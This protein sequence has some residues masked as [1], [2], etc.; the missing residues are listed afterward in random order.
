MKRKFTLTI[1]L[2]TMCLCFSGCAKMIVLTEGEEDAIA[3]F[4]A[5]VI[6]KFN[7]NMSKGAT[8]VVLDKP[9]KETPVEEETPQDTPGGEGDGNAG[10]DT[11]DS[12][13]AKP[14]SEVIGIEGLEFSLTG[15]NAMESYQMSDYLDLR[16]N[17]GKVYLAA[18]FKAQNASEAP[19]DVD[20][21]AMKLRFTALV[22]GTSVSSES[23]ILP[24]DLSMYSGQIGPGEEQGLV[25]LFQID[26]EKATEDMSGT[27]L[28]VR[29]DSLVY[30]IAK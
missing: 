16:P 14:L 17:E 18:S 19:I 8:A 25:V 21:K 1:L 20:L 29:K 9:A 30:Q 5:S 22:E 4:S 13:E 27:K 23:T 28:G 10:Q 15:I 7:R 11:L 12:S 26:R 6:S 3:S 2:L 24:N